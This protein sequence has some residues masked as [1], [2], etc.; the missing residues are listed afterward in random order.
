MSS[1]PTPNLERRT[2]RRLLLAVLP[3]G[4]DFEA[5]CLDYFSNIYA[6]FGSAMDREAKTNLLLEAIPASEILTRLRQAKPSATAKHERLVE[7]G[8][9]SSLL[10]DRE[11]D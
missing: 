2:V 10:K 9:Q 3:V 8:A 11:Q 7:S 4:S 6:R 5:F 1:T